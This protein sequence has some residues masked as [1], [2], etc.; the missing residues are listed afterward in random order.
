MQKG[1]IMTDLTLIADS[2][3]THIQRTGK[4]PKEIVMSR[5][6]LED[7]FWGMVTEFHGIPVITKEDC[8]KGMIYFM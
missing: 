3:A 5:I 1:I 4:R 7:V 6:T 2:L 8:P